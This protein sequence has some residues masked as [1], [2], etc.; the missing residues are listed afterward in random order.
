M[1]YLDDEAILNS[2]DFLSPIPNP[3]LVNSINFEILIILSFAN[4]LVSTLVVGF[5]ISHGLKYIK[6]IRLGLY[7]FLPILIF[8]SVFV[9]GNIANWLTGQTVEFWVTGQTSFTSIFGFDFFILRSAIFDAELVGITYVLS[10]PYLF[11]RYVFNV[12]IWGLL[13]HYAKKD[14]K[15]KG[16]SGSS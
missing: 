9:S 15:S 12:I 1:P 13:I 8:I 11:S 3:T 16:S 5:F 7:I 4:I 6:N 2:A 14:F 10:I